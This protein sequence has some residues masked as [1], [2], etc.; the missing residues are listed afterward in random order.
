MGVLGVVFLSRAGRALGIDA[1]L[2]KR[3]GERFTLLW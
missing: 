2:A 1:F 3:F